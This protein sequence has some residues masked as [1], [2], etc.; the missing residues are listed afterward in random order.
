[1]RAS[2][3]RDCGCDLEISEREIECRGRNCDLAL[4]VCVLEVQVERRRVYALGSAGLGDG[5]GSLGWLNG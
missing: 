3:G 5:G 2:N 1:V 4:R